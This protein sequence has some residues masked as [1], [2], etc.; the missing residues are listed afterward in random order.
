MS[1]GQREDC[2]V[3][4][5]AGTGPLELAVGIGRWTCGANGPPQVDE[6]YEGFEGK[7]ADACSMFGS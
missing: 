6:I 1:V 4:T 3:M 5:V 7:K 2:T